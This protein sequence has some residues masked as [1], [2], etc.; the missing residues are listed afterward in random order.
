MKDSTKETL[1]NYQKKILKRL[2]NIYCSKYVY[3]KLAAF[4]IAAIITLTCSLVFRQQILESKEK[5]WE[6]IPGFLNI[7]I[8]QNTGIAFSGLQN[9][10]SSL[11][12]FVQSI[13][14]IIGFSILILSHSIFID[15][16]LS[17]ILWGGLAN[18]IDRTLIDNYKYLHVLDTENA[19]VDYLQFSFIKNSAVFNFADASIVFGIII[20]VLY[21][22]YIIIKDFVINSKNNSKKSM[23]EQM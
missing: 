11:V 21:V 1:L 2:K 23:E 7:N 12:Y 13:P 20:A 10:S 18:I 5:F 6:F 16:G 8:V 22:I 3:L 9:Q 15:L 14:V 17:F 19:V 4:L